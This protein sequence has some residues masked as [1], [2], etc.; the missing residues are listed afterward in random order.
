[1]PNT[2]QP[3]SCGSDWY[4]GQ[5]AIVTGGGGGIGRAT[6]LALHEQGVAV[7]ALDHDQQ[8]VTQMREEHPQIEC[9]VCDIT[10]HDNLEQLVND[11]IAR[12]KYVDILVNN[13]GIEYW[14]LL[15]E[16][17]IEQWRRTHAVNIEA[18][19]VLSKLVAPGMIERKHGRIV[20]VSSIKAFA[21]VHGDTAYTATKAGVCGLTRALAVELGQHNVLVNAVAPGDIRTGI[22]MQNDPPV[23]RTSQQDADAAAA[24]TIPMQRPGTPEEAAQAILFLCSSQSTY[25]N[26]HTLVV[27]GGLMA[28][29]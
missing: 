20:N 17:T 4:A 21:A 19:Y 24:S 5:V 22:R 10:D 3:A 6:A 11:V 18:M 27:D 1:M 28:R 13:A 7:V 23:K 29:L 12:H 2:G 15:T 25:V 26:G 8:R 16:S 14:A 9:L